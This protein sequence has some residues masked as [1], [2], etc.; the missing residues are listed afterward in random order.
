[1]ELNEMDITIIIIGVIIFFKFRK[2]H[3]DIIINNKD[4]DNVAY[5]KITKDRINNVSKSEIRHRI[6]I[7]YYDYTSSEERDRNYLYRKPLDLSKF[8]IKE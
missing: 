3:D 1:M 6:A 8:D 2:I 4:L 5:M 7:G